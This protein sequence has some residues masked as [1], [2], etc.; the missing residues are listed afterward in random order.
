[1]S[2]KIRRQIIAKYFS[3][4]LD[5]QLISR[6]DSNVKEYVASCLDTEKQ[7]DK[8]IH[9]FRNGCVRWDDEKG[10]MTSSPVTLINNQQGMGGWGKLMKWFKIMAD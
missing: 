9:S 3:F 7:L 4:R 8:L 6:L 2:V 1:M 5:K 10:C